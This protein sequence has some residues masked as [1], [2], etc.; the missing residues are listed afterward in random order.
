MTESRNGKAPAVEAVAGS[1]DNMLAP[2]AAYRQMMQH[3][4]QLGYK[5]LPG[6]KMRVPHEGGGYLVKTNQ[7]G[8]RCNNEVTPRK[9][10]ARRVLVFGDSY[11]AGEGVS[12]GTR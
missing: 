3:D 2:A 5:F 4:P 8:Y 9:P 12:N 6:L 7:E 11:T 1:A 10:K